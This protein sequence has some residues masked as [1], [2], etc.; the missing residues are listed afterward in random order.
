M[1]SGGLPFKSPFFVHKVVGIV[2]YNS[3]AYAT[4]VTLELR[5]TDGSG[6][7][8]TADI[9]ALIDAT[10]DKAVTVSGV[11]AALVLTGNAAV[12]VRAA[13]GNPA[14]GDSPVAFE[15]TYSI[16]AVTI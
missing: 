2:D 7:K 4:N 6:T 13:S 12:V 9:G 15:V 5:Y 10:A 11:E 16:V 8:V 14:T 3:A 1:V